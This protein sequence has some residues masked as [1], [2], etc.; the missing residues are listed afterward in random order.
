VEKYLKNVLMRICFPSRFVRE[1]YPG[2]PGTIFFYL[3][4][5]FAL[6]Y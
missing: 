2:Y 5:A 6:M 1:I 4:F 3:L